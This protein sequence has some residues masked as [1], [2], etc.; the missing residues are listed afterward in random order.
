[1]SVLATPIVDWN[2]MWKI[3]LVVLIAGV[4]T[5]VAFGFL[6]LGLKLAHRLGNSGTETG[7]ATVG[8]YLLAG[9]CAVIVIGVVVIGI[10]AMS[11]KPSSKPA[12]PKAALVVPA[13]TRVML[14]AS[15]R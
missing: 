8:G 9:G 4:G 1:M 10:Y 2:A 14:T 5:V 12:K 15:S 11:H 13:P 3:F 7:G 6:L